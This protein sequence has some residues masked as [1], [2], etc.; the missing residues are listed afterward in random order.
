MS[1]IT[2]SK[3]SLPTFAEAKRYVGAQQKF[4]QETVKRGE[5]ATDRA[6]YATYLA[7]HVLHVIA[8]PRNAQPE[9]HMTGEE[10]AATFGRQSK[11]LTTGW[12]T[13][14]HV[15]VEVGLSEENATYIRLRNSN[16]YTDKDV[17]A[18]CMAEGATEETISA[19]LD[20]KGITA[21]GKRAPREKGAKPDEGEGTGAEKG[22]QVT[23]PRNNSGLLDLIEKAVASL[24]DL[25]PAEAE[26]VAVIADA[27]AG[28]K[29]VKVD[30]KGTG[31]KAA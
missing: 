8:Q 29:V 6:A 12:R 19:A 1:T 24:S 10:W 20:A 31:R 7:E 14:G 15:L 4:M 30:E 28:L 2:I 27:M 17:K 13:L 11:S 3:S 5:N 18:A 23:M 26:R 21:E 16:A 25:T 9:G 22:A